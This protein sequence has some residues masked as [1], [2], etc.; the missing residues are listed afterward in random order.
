MSCSLVVDGAKYTKLYEFM[1]VDAAISCEQDYIR[2]GWRVYRDITTV[3][4]FKDY[5]SFD[6]R[7]SYMIKRSY[8][9][10]FGNPFYR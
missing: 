3:K 4:C 5:N 2:R 10:H 7:W 6:N 8:Y 9:E 1:T